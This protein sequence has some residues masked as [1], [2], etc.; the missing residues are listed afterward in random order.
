MFRFA[1]MSM[2]VALLLLLA[3]PA[4]AQTYPNVL[5]RT[6]FTPAAN[7]MSLSGY[8]RFLYMQQG[9]RY[10]SYSRRDYDKIVKE[11]L[12]QRKLPVSPAP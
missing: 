12:R 8:L 1:L 3:P 2:V 10:Y 7:Y 9:G 6:A 5:D 11:Q 4:A